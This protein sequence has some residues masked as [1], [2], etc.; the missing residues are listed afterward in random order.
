MELLGR[1]FVIARQGVPVSVNLD[2]TH[3]LA[4][5]HETR[6]GLVSNLPR[7]WLPSIADAAFVR[8]STAEQARRLRGRADAYELLLRRLAVA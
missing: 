8:D 4:D 1:T 3:V 5:G 6:A 7:D 2:C